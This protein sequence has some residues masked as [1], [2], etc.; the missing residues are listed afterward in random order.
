[1]LVETKFI[2]MMEI[3]KS[4]LGLFSTNNMWVCVWKWSLE[5]CLYIKEQVRIYGFIYLYL[6]MNIPIYL[7][8]YI[9]IANKIMLIKLQMQEDQ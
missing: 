1:M 2:F 7:P 6:C 8:L 3:F 4:N 5:S 9:H